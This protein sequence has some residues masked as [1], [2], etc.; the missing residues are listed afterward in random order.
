M[1]LM[2]KVAIKKTCALT[3]GKVFGKHSFPLFGI[4]SGLEWQI[5]KKGGNR[6]D[7]YPPL[8]VTMAPP[9]TVEA[10]L[11]KSAIFNVNEYTIP[12]EGVLLLFDGVAT[13]R[14]GNL[15]PRGKLITT[16]LQSTGGKPPHKNDLFSLSSKDFFPPIFRSEESVITLASCWQSAFYH[17]MF[18]VLP[19]LHLAEKGGFPL[20]NVYIDT[21]LPFQKESLD[22]LELSEKQIISAH[23]YAGVY[24]PQLIVPSVP[25]TPSFWSCSYLRHKLIPKLTRRDPI[26]LYISRRDASRRRVINEEEVISCLKR[27]DFTC[28]TLGDLPFKEQ[29]EYFLAANIVLGPHG[30]GFSHLVFCNPKIPVLEIF[31]PKY[32]NPCYWHICDR[33]GLSYY[34]LFG[35]EGYSSHSDL[36]P[37]I[38]VNLDKLEASLR[39][40]GLLR[41]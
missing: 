5:E 1:A 28:I 31:S 19:R 13:Y 3:L 37:D 26:R 18:E 30:A 34:T 29:A 35:E 6:I 8:P 23:T 9:R 40:M 38:Y 10:A 39:L 21:S 24:A 12:G 22:L 2:S 33:V 36:D 20:K 7:I 27:Y 14:G 15:S 11:S 41:L 32:V 17:W 25:H 16:Y 4:P